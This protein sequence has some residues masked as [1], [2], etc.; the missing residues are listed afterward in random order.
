MQ[1]HLSI[2]GD[3]QEQPEPCWTSGS[4]LGHPKT[5]VDLGGCKDF[6]PPDMAPVLGYPEIQ[7]WSQPSPSP[8]PRAGQ[9][10]VLPQMRSKASQVSVHIGGMA[11]S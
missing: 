2:K 3:I 5:V 10:S 8:P 4:L 6:G 11:D 9:V 1:T 7:T